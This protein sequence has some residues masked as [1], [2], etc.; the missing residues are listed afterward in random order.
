MENILSMKKPFCFILTIL[1]FGF[2]SNAQKQTQEAYRISFK[3]KNFK[4]STAVLGHYYGNNQ[5]VPKDT[6]R[7]D[8]NGNLVFTGKKSL[9]GG[10]YLLVLPGSKYVEVII[11]ESNFTMEFD[12]IDVVASMVVKNSPEN[13][14]F[15]EFQKFMSLK[16][17]EAVLFKEKAKNNNSDTAKMAKAKLM[18]L[19]KEIKSFR[20]NSFN[21]NSKLFAVRVLKSA[22]DPEVPEPP[23]LPSGVKDSVFAYRYYKNHYFD[24]IDL[25]DDRMIRTP[26]FHGKLERYFKQLVVQVPDSIKNDADALILKSKSPELFKYI[27]WYITNTYENSQIMG[28][29]AVFVHMAKTYY[30]SGKA[31]WVDS[32]I[33]AKIRDRVKILEPILLGKIAPN[34]FLTDSS[35]KLFPLSNVKAKYTILYFWDPDCGHCQKVTPELGEFYNKNKEKG[36]EVYGA[37]IFRDTAKIKVWKKF[38]RDKK[39]KFTNVWDSYVQT[40]FKNLYDIY[41][42]PVIYILDEKK[43]ILAKRI[44]VE[45]LPDFFN[46]GLKLKVD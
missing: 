35:G 32:G 23:M 9:P 13:Q 22:L 16:G 19:D 44:G 2:L 26:V 21:L 39:L 7:A 12:T 4:D 40:D 36:I 17:Q 1:L 6:A 46:N 29:D 11:G 30:L 27:V 28:M 8:R 37:S 31:T 24:N 5:Y 43:K 38:I 34:M 3:I 15:Y 42:T 45:Q 33:V 10:V 41:S 25:T 14:V 20:E 18:E